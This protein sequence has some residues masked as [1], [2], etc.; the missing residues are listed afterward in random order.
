MKNS[1]DHFSFV[2]SIADHIGLSLSG[3]S[4]YRRY[5]DPV[6]N[7]HFNDYILCINNRF[8]TIC[9]IF[10]C[11]KSRYEV[12]IEFNKHLQSYT[13]LFEC[14][15]AFIFEFDNRLWYFEHMNMYSKNYILSD[16][17]SVDDVSHL[18]DTV[19]TL[20]S[21]AGQFTNSLSGYTDHNKFFVDF[22]N[23]GQRQDNSIYD[24]RLVNEFDSRMGQTEPFLTFTDL[25][26]SFELS[27]ILPHSNGYKFTG[28]QG[29]CGTP[30]AY[31]YATA[32]MFSTFHDTD[33]EIFKKIDLLEIDNAQEVVKKIANIR[34][35][36]YTANP[37]F[38]YIDTIKTIPHLKRIVDLL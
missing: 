27:R 4:Y 35:S 30:A 6:V 29:F 9:E 34:M 21:I 5:S 37:L 26:K 8:I 3:L 24:S 36:L 18:L 31:G 22:V 14:P 1:V 10:D 33:D 15:D 17:M 32:V 20:N 19:K 2:K 16:K 13:D 7:P 28:L 11:S 23:K 12:L 25:E 38:C